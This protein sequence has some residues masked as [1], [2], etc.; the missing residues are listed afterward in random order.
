MAGSADAP[1]GA[2]RASWWTRYAQLRDYVAE[3]GH[4]P[5]PKE[6]IGSF[7]VGSWIGRQRK[8]KK[9]RTWLTPEQAQALEMIPGWHWGRRLKI[10]WCVKFAQLEVFVAER[11]RL[12]TRDETTGPF[13]VGI[14]TSNQR[15]AKRYKRL[16]DE[17]VRA[18]EGLPGWY[19]EQD[20]DAEWR[21]KFEVLKTFATEHG[22]IP[23]KSG[24]VGDFKIGIWVNTQRQV[25]KG[26]GGHIT[27]ERQRIL[28]ELPGWHWGQDQDKEWRE[29]FEALKAYVAERGRIPAESEAIGD[30]RVGNWIG[31]QRRAKRGGRITA[32][33]IRALE[34]LPGWLWEQDLDAAWREK[35]GKLEA[36]VASRKRL[37]AKRESIGDFG[38]GRW[39]S[40]QRQAMRRK[41]GRRLT[42]DQVQAME[43]LLRQFGG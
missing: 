13:K 10:E 23:T 35:F 39:L 9:A 6:K 40:N 8:A 30:F 16:S 28:D 32:E 1:C 38:V 18:L 41:G 2:R 25:K 14:W 11:G 31:H 37:P 36:Y 5:S 21:E 3:R 26:Q 4:L 15:S 43:R 42:P 24:T 17:Q 19:W 22:R 29:K 34:E 20:P 7:G 27:A 12:P 33:Q